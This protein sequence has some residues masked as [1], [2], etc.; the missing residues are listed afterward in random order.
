MFNTQLMMGLLSSCILHSPTDPYRLLRSPQESSG[1]CEEFDSFPYKL[2]RVCQDSLQTPEDSLQTPEDSLQ[3]PEDSLQ[4]PHKP[5]E[6]YIKTFMLHIYR[7]HI[8]L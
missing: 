1:V 8:Y 7:I 3:T 4:T 6:N 2:I 5:H